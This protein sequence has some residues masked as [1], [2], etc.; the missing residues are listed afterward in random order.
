MMKVVLMVLLLAT[1]AV[2]QFSFNFGDMFEEQQGGGG[3]GGGNGGGAE[4]A[5]EDIPKGFQCRDTDYVVDHPRQCPCPGH[6]MVKCKLDDW[7]AC[8]PSGSKCP[9][10]KFTSMDDVVAP[11]YDDDEEWE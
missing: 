11:Q 7:Y 5:A 2:A 8:L 9:E 6:K 10:G 3:G 4:D 1:A